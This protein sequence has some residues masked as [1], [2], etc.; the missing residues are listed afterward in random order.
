MVPT[1]EPMGRISRI[2]NRKWIIC[3]TFDG[4]SDFILPPSQ[5]SNS[6]CSTSHFTRPTKLNPTCLSHSFPPISRIICATIFRPISRITGINGLGS[7]GNTKSSRDKCLSR[8][9]FTWIFDSFLPTARN[10][11]ATRLKSSRISTCS[12]QTSKFRPG[13]LE[14]TRITYSSPF[15]TRTTGNTRSESMGIC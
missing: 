4:I 15:T 3:T 12:Y 5:L 14:L 10:T 11:T 6:F 9:E 7:I 13:R 2:S 8:L 1:V